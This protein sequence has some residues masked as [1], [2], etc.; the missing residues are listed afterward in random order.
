MARKHGSR[1]AARINEWAVTV[2]L[3]DGRVLFWLGEESKRLGHD[4]GP[5]NQAFRFASE[6]EADNFAAKCATN[7]KAWEYRTVR[8]PQPR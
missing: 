8:L 7:S 6:A 5:E 1:R 4:W 3:N 2:R